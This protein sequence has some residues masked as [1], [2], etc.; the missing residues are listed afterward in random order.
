MVSKW[1][2]LTTLCVAIVAVIIF[3]LVALIKKNEQ[4]CNMLRKFTLRCICLG[5]VAIVALLGV[6]SSFDF[7]SEYLTRVMEPESIEN[8]RLLFKTMFGTESVF[9]SLQMVIS[10]L[11]V[12]VSLLSGLFC[13]FAV[14]NLYRVFVR[15]SYCR[16]EQN[17][18]PKQ[19]KRVC[20]VGVK[21]P[22]LYSKLLN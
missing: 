18:F 13:V 1:M 19:C 5:V 16:N 20:F 4:L 17:A 12:T 2:F 11:M 9:S 6:F 15:R 22:F 3:A 10:L 21:I 8:F 14:Q 7:F